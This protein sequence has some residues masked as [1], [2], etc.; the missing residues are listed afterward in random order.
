VQTLL[1]AI[2]SLTLWGRISAS[3]SSPRVVE[4]RAAYFPLVGL[5][6]GLLLGVSHYV[7]AP[8]LDPEILN[9]VIISLWISAT[10]AMH[11]K[12]LKDTFDALEKQDGQSNGTLGITAVLIVILLKSAALNSMDEMLTLSLLLSPL[13]ARWAALLFFF[14]YNT[15]FDEATRGIA[16]HTSIWPVLASTAATLGLAFYF[17]GRKGLWITL[18]LSL[19]TLSLRALLHRGHPLLSNSNVDAVVELTEGLSLIL[20]ASL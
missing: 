8:Y 15:R 1:A 19:F 7:L 14:G 9:I 11:L 20:L 16:Q 17:L 3:G 4:K 5:I 2:K 12:G 10:G 13:F 6:V 18:I